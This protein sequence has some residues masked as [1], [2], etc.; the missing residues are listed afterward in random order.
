MPL[1]DLILQLVDLC[2]CK[3]VVAVEIAIILESSGEETFG[4]VIAVNGPEA[5]EGK[6]FL[7]LDLE[8]Y[9]KADDARACKQMP[10]LECTR[11]AGVIDSVMWCIPV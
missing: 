9:M 7:S 8:F 6:V 5:G 4:R 10:Y 11:R 1:S 2:S 3:K